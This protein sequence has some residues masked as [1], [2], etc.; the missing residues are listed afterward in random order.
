MY[1]RLF[2]RRFKF[3][4]NGEISRAGHGRHLIYLFALKLSFK[5]SVTVAN[6]VCLKCSLLYCCLVQSTNRGDVSQRDVKYLYC[7]LRRHARTFTFNKSSDI[8]LEENTFTVTKTSG[9]NWDTS[10]FVNWGK[11]FLFS[12]IWDSNATLHKS[13]Y[14]Y[15]CY[16]I[17]ACPGMPCS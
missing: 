4:R 9:F 1:L 8:K 2:L 11:R 6:V 5:L 7:L 12:P 17:L 14:H 15:L 10:V 16:I 3:G 13:F